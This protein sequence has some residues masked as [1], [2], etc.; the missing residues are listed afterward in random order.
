MNDLLNALQP[1]YPP[2]T[3]EWL[4]VLAIALAGAVKVFRGSVMH[5]RARRID[6]FGWS[7]ISFD[8]V[9]G[10]VLLIGAMWAFYPH[11]HT[12]WFDLSITITLLAVTLWQGYTVYSAPVHRIDRAISPQATTEWTPEDGERRSGVDRRKSEVTQ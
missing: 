6:F 3:T 8:Y 9:F 5:R 7:I 2:S 4:H 1:S 11:L 12:K 10:A